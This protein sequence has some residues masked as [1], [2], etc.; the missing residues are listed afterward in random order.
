MVQGGEGQ[1]PLLGLAPSQ[2][3]AELRGQEVREGQGRYNLKARDATP[4]LH[5]VTM[6][7]TLEVRGAGGMVGDLGKHRI[8]TRVG[9][10]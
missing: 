6:A 7:G 10:N 1:A 4:G 8:S 3:E 2:G 5:E 9:R